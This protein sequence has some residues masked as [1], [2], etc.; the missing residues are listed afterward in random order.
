MV[1]FG[2]LRILRVANGILRAS[3]VNTKMLSSGNIVAQRVGAVDLKT[4]PPKMNKLNINKD[5]V[6]NLICLAVL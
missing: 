3:P 6:S 1:A 2:S 5:G 4:A